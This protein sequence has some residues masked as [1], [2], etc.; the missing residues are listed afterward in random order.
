M[1]STGACEKMINKCMR[2]TFSNFKSLSHT[3]EAGGG[4]LE[5]GGGNVD[6]TG[7]ET[8]GAVVTGGKLTGGGNSTTGGGNETGG[9]KLAGAVGRS[10][11]VSDMLAL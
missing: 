7:V 2:G 1:A 3:K 10:Q 11:V 9:G 6:T 5:T 4:K 8:A